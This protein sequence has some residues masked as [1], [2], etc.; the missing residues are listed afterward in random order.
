MMKPGVRNVVLVPV[1]SPLRLN[2]QS[3]QFIA[4]LLGGTTSGFCNYGRLHQATLINKPKNRL[5]VST[6]SSHGGIIK[7]WW[8]L[9]DKSASASPAPTF[10]NSVYHQTFESPPGGNNANFKAGS[11]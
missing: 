1:S 10:Q 8:V 5:L 9:D 7:L 4:L 3:V 6:K 2:D 11:D